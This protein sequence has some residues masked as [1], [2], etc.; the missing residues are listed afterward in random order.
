MEQG[1]TGRC[2]TVHPTHHRIGLNTGTSNTPHN[3]AQHRY[4]QHTTQ[5]GST[6]AHSTHHMTALK[7][8]YIHHT[9]RL[10][11]TPVH[12]THHTNGLNTGTFN[13]P[14]DCAPTPVHPTHHT[15]GLNT[16]TSN[17]PH[18]WAQHRFIQRTTR[19]G[20]TPV[21][22]KHHTTGFQH[23]PFRASPFIL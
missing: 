17:T 21:H 16:G 12:P 20:S 23:L 13:T 5:M 14:H 9:T 8:R 2:V 4:I 18:N 1:I 10:G 15:T 6:P 3:W 7:H 11:S 22:P 19:L